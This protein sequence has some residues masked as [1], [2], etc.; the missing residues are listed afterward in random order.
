M[1]NVFKLFAVGVMLA[2]SGLNAQGV[3][4]TALPD[5]VLRFAENSDGSGDSCA[6]PFVTSTWDFRHDD[7]DGEPNC[8]NDQ[9]SYFKLDNVSSATN[10]TLDSERCA[11]EEERWSY[12]LNTYIQPVTSRWVAISELVGL[13]KDDIVVRGV[14]VVRAYNTGEVSTKG[15]LSCVRIK[16]SALP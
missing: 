15:K 16:R 11:G 4:A 12:T 6:V 1:M 8:T 9:M 5:G 2:V 10:F 14:R 3:L 13:V 7:G